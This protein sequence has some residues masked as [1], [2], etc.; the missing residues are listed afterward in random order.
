MIVVV[1]LPQPNKGGISGG[2]EICITYPTEFVKTQLQ[3]DERSAKPRYTGIADVVKQTIRDKGVFGLYK[4]LPPLLYGSVPKSAVRFGGYELF[5]SRL[6]DQNGKLSQTNT[7][8][9]GLGAGVTE[10]IFAV[11][12]MET[13]KVKFIHD[14]NLPNPQY[15]SF[16]QGVATI[17]RQ[18]GIGGIYRGLLP[19]ILKQGTNQAMRFFVY[20][21]VTGWM[22][23][24]GQKLTPFHTLFAGG[25]AGFISVYGNTPIDVVKTR[26]QGLEAH[27]YKGAWDCAR[28]IWTKEGFP[29]FY[30]GTV[31]RL[32]RVV[33]DTAI[34][35]TLYE[36][37]VQGLDLIWDTSHY[38]KK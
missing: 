29:A 4:G 36:Y 16:P 5:R 37:I 28:T 32:G 35:F 20:N 6:V 21:N 25:L 18:E 10:A 34:V 19:T 38:T 24:D 12:P 3:L 8:L 27:K 9:A 22:T 31:P 23:K 2:I 7:L 30:K 13:I 11:C 1:P 14:Q 17:I 33:L 15:K 26:M